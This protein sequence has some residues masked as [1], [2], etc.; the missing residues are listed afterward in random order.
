MTYFRELDCFGVGFLEPVGRVV[1][2]TLCTDQPWSWWDVDEKCNATPGRGT[3]V[4]HALMEALTPGSS[5]YGERE[6][7]G[8][9]GRKLKISAN[10]VFSICEVPLCHEKNRAYL[11]VR[12]GRR[13]VA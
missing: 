8:E 7:V 1:V 12:V 2:S 9:M 5:R 10:Y 4:V 11:Q 6:V 3:Y 13:I